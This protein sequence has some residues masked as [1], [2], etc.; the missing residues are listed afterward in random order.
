MED[1]RANGGAEYVMHRLYVL[2]RTRIRTFTHAMRLNGF[3]ISF[4]IWVFGP[5]YAAAYLFGGSAFLNGS[6]TI[7]SVYLIFHYISVMEG[8]LWES[9]RQVEDLQ[10]AV[11][12]INRIAALFA[13]EP[14][15]HDGPGV[16]LPPNALAVEF[17]QVSFHY[18]DDVERV[19]QDLS[20]QL[21]PGHVL[22]L[23]GRTGSGKSTLSKLLFR[24]YQPSDGAIRL[25]NGNGQ[26]VDMRDARQADL[27]GRI[28]MVTQEVQ[29]FH[30]TVRDNLTLFNDEISDER[31]REVIDEVGLTEWFAALPSGLDTHLGSSADSN[32]SA[33]E[34]QLLAFARVFL[35]D[36]G[37]IIL[38]EA[39]SR[40]DP[41][42]EQR[43][44]QALDKLLQDRTGIIIAHRLATVQRA[45]EIMILEKGTIGEYGSR[46]QLAADPTSRFSQLLKTGLEEAFA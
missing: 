11:A 35:T 2:M 31:V 28:G 37:L 3:V 1:I 42:T 30:A 25:G 39:S 23:L 40:L 46:A 32:L 45:D 19:I 44:E 12:S 33:G 4:P 7:G 41:A 38:D 9:I 27:Q 17:D 13:V 8:P 21:Q 6:L 26:M 43:V 5:A 36:P 18:E 34:A 24:F 22:G 10:R 14:R 15:I 29:L 16:T 20:F